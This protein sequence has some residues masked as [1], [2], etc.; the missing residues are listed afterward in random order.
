[1]GLDGK[2]RELH[3]SQSLA[4]ID[5]SDFEPKLVSANFTTDGKT[6]KRSL[7]HDTLFDIEAWR[8]PAETD[9]A[10]KPHKLQIVAVTS[11]QAEIKSGATGLDLV[12]G[13]FCLVPASLDKT[14]V[15]AKNA[16]ELLRV[17]AH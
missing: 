1:M 2:P 16:V 6:H 17:E 5:F 7:V 11:G 10:L 3:V 12:A 15:I 14:E 4:S 9:C 13:Q 8:L